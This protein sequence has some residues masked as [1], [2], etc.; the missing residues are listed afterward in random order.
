MKIIYQNESGGVSV[1]I[2]TGELSIELTP[3]F[4]GT[5]SGVV[6]V[7]TNS[8][9]QNI[10]VNTNFYDDVSADIINAKD[11][12]SLL[13]DTGISSFVLDDIESELTQA[14]DDINFGN[15]RDA[16]EGFAIASAKVALLTDIVSAG[17]VPPTENGSGGDSGLIIIILVVALAAL[18]GV[19]LYLK[20]FRKSGGG[21]GSDEDIEKELGV[22]E[23]EGY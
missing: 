14:E 18:G 5:Y 10:L 15:F 1:I 13:Y 2:P 23:E 9:S 20:K 12:L 16:A 7:S 3:A 4:A 19:L 8:G 11:D 6:T 22:D 17:Y 21:F